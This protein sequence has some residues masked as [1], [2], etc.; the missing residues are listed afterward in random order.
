MTKREVGWLIVRLA[1]LY[2]LWNAVAS[3]PALL[4]GLHLFLEGLGTTPR[5]SGAVFFQAFVVTVIY[6]ALG[7]YCVNDGRVFFHLL[8]RESDG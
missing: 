1:G 5:G 8:S 6:A 2:C 7:L 3:S 4:A